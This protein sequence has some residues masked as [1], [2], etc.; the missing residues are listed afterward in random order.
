MK[1]LLA[2]SSSSFPKISIAFILVDR[3]LKSFDNPENQNLD[4]F[5]V[6]EFCKLRNGSTT[7]TQYFA[8]TV[9]SQADGSLFM[10]F[11]DF[12]YSINCNLTSNCFHD[13]IVDIVDLM[14]GGRDV[15]GNNKPVDRWS[16]SAMRKANRVLSKAIDRAIRRQKSLV[17]WNLG[18]EVT[19]DCLSSTRAK[20]YWIVKD[21]A[22][23]ARSK[24]FYLQQVQYRSPLPIPSSMG[25]Q[26]L[27]EA[28]PMPHLAN[29]VLGYRERSA[30]L[31]MTLMRTDWTGR[32]RS[33]TVGY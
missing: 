4:D 20:V 33:Q 3:I 26:P 6:A 2:A 30:T 19:E 29:A 22:E 9:G 25:P 23:E 14:T 17:E 24:D 10:K 21:A 31:G 28:L 11:H 1:L 8:Y 15:H 16:E 13:D 12:F 32:V 27:R 5:T 7:F 18:Y